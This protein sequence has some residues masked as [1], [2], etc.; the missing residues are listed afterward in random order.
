MSCWA[1]FVAGPVVL[2]CCADSDSDAQT[3]EGD[4]QQQN[5][6]KVEAMHQPDDV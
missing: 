6:D 5:P 1:S 4:P 2:S 3:A